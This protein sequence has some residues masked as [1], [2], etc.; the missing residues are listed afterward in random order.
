MATSSYKKLPTKQEFY[1][2]LNAFVE[3]AFV[4]LRIKIPAPGSK[5]YH[6]YR[7]NDEGNKI[8]VPSPNSGRFYNAI[9][10]PGAINLK[11]LSRGSGSAGRI[12]FKVESNEIYDPVFK[13][14]YWNKLAYSYKTDFGSK[15]MYRNFWK[16]AAKQLKGK[17]E[18]YAL[19]Y[20]TFRPK[21]FNSWEDSAKE[22]YSNSLNKEFDELYSQA[23]EEEIL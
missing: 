23:E 14:N 12:V 17:L 22:E 4:D 11:G 2:K 8:A 10:K 7:I 9:K 6:L 1:S 16:P 3:E 20:A 19:S 13:E 21:G 18:S 15:N 5:S